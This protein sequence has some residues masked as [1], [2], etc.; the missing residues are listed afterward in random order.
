MEDYDFEIN[1]NFAVDISDAASPSHVNMASCNREDIVSIIG[2]CGEDSEFWD[3]NTDSNEVSSVQEENLQEVLCAERVG[4]I[5]K[6]YSDIDAVTRLLEEK[7]R[8]L[9]LTARIGQSLLKKVKVLTERNEYLEEKIEHVTEEVSQLRHDL[10]LKDELLHIYTNNSAESDAEQQD[11]L[12]PL[13]DSSGCSFFI[14]PK[15]EHTDSVQKKLH[16]LESENLSL[17]TEA[18]H[19]KNETVNYE[20]KEKQLVNDCIKELRQTSTQLTTLTEDLMRRSDEAA[21]QQEQI[22]QLL[23]QVVDLQR[24]VK[25]FAADN[26][27]LN[28]HLA[29]AKE[30]QKE[31]TGEL[32][33]IKEKMQQCTGMLHEAQ[34]EAK[35]LRNKAGMQATSP[36]WFHPLVNFPMDSLAAEI[37]G[38][39][40]RQL[41]DSAN[42]DKSRERRMF[43]TVRNV[44]EAS[45]RRLR[46][47]S[48]LPIPGSNRTSTFGSNQS[49]SFPSPR[50]SYYGSE[51]S[52]TNRSLDVDMGSEGEERRPGQPGMP[53]SNDLETALRRLAVRREALLSERRFMDEEWDRRLL[54]LS[55]T[56]AS[57]S[58]LSR[59]STPTG[60]DSSDSRSA[61]SC[62]V[63]SF[64]PDKLQIVKPL[65]GSTTL[66]HWQH[67]AQP[68]LEGILDMRPGVLTKGN[69]IYDAS[70]S[71]GPADPE[72][73]EP[74]KDVD[75]QQDEMAVD[76]VP[77]LDKFN[78]IPAQSAA[79]D[80]APY[81]GKCSDDARYTYTLTTCRIIH[82]TDDTT[83]V[84]SA[85]QLP[86]PS[87]VPLSL[88]PKQRSA[89]ACVGHPHRAESFTN[90]RD[91]TRTSS[92]TLGLAQL[93]QKCGISAAAPRRLPSLP[94]AA[95]LCSGPQTVLFPSTP[96]SNMPTNE[97]LPVSSLP[98]LLSR[99]TRGRVSE[100]FLASRPA[101]S[102][103]EEIMG[104]HGGATST[105][106]QPK[107]SCS[108]LALVEQL[109]RL[110]ISLA[111]T[112]RSEGATIR[113]K[114]DQS[115]KHWTTVASHLADL[116]WN[117]GGNKEADAP[118]HPVAEDTPHGTPSTEKSLPQRCHTGPSSPSQSLMAQPPDYTKVPSEMVPTNPSCFRR[119]SEPRS[120]VR[121]WFSSRS[122]RHRSLSFSGGFT[123]SQQK[124]SMGE[125]S[126]GPK[127][128][129]L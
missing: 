110:G 37:E 116:P 114:T 74:C 122:P 30:A 95:G 5:T 112:A 6:T 58:V 1:E 75:H 102:I 41:E 18:S 26:D 16:F 57:T 39:M 98:P 28:Q 113:E 129:G 55:R 103:L 83:S 78:S 46:S 52:A 34:E 108:H 51:T 53:G 87:L 49:S 71:R 13:S 123:M 47:L 77:E 38:T 69:S 59:P 3:L 7:E 61:M 63:R 72:E 27:E 85:S 115:C 8:D 127:T 12:P 86:G 91:A 79:Q 89:T 67:L 21:R 118:S 126:Q 111:G 93:M 117:N 124:P 50:S 44:N 42:P 101:T 106:N 97:K 76:A 60:S 88:R 19:L 43:D 80:T 70:D 99:P 15:A 35:N 81:P 9:E 17:R 36:R 14:G 73:D 20:E 100:P 45:K 94:A 31:L 120:S 121:T 66:Q 125:T 40:R 68:N 23:A 65:E 24:K 128:E 56:T 119:S 25:T 90:V 4:Q 29:A 22:T 33:Y 84:S 54:E 48:P 82:P 62:G 96:T 92:T 105:G 64:L 10:S 11:D 32:R 107:W 2:S 109:H 104:P